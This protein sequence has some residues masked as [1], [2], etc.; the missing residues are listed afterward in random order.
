MRTGSSTPAIDRGS[1]PRGCSRASFVRPCI[2]GNAAC[3]STEYSPCRPGSRQPGLSA[4]TWRIDLAVAE[5]PR[6]RKLDFRIT[7]RPVQVTHVNDYGWIA[8]VRRSAWQLPRGLAPDGDHLGDRFSPRVPLDEKASSVTMGGVHLVNVPR[9]VHAESSV[10][11]GEG[12]FRSAVSGRSAT[13]DPAF[14]PWYCRQAGYKTDQQCSPALEFFIR[15][16]VP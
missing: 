11:V 5:A 15:L 2:R 14:G 13:A 9:T 1:R 8:V 6:T 7:N 12:H 3:R 10:D 16:Q 4:S